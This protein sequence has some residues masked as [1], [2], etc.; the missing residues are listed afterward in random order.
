MDKMS[1]QRIFFEAEVHRSQY[2]EFTQREWENVVDNLN[3]LSMWE[4]LRALASI[5]EPKREEVVAQAKRVLEDNRGWKNPSDR[6]QWAAA[7]VTKMRFVTPRAGLFQRPPGLV[8]S[9]EETDAKV[10]LEEHK[11]KTAKRGE[12]ITLHQPSIATNAAGIFIR[13]R[14]Q[15]THTI[16]RSTT[17]E[18]IIDLVNSKAPVNH[19]AMS[20]HGFIDRTTGE[21]RADIGTGLDH[22]NVGLFSKLRGQVGVIWF[23]GCLISASTQGHKD[24]IERAR[25]ADCFLVAPAFLM[26]GGGGDLPLGRMDMNRRFMPKVFDP[27]GGLVSWDDFLDMGKKLK[28]TVT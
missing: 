8:E 13:Y 26:A 27:G 15:F 9:P 18:E 24:C 6:I 17:A 16:K 22:S 10:F 23:G 4:M 20:C 5:S 1:T 21:A 7:I 2:A 14:M 3:A 11:G 12:L 28:F 25:K 19:W